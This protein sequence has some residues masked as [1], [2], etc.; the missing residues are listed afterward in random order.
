MHRARKRGRIGEMRGGSRRLFGRIQQPA[1]L[2]TADHFA[3]F[4]AD[5]VL[6]N[7][8]GVAGQTERILHFGQGSGVHGTS[9]PPVGVFVDAYRAALERARSVVGVH[10][11]SKLSGTFQA[12]AEAASELGEGVTVFDSLNLSG[13][14]ALVTT[15]AARAAARC[16]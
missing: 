10:I 8:L 2:A 16:A 13:G 12:A 9:Q 3:N 7:H 11:S 4:D 6:G 5:T 1:A 14:L 15:A